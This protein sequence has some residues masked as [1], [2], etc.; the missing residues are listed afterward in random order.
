MHPAP[1]ACSAP[2]RSPATT[3]VLQDA[4]SHSPSSLLTARCKFFA[5]CPNAWKSGAPASAAVVEHCADSNEISTEP[6]S[7]RPVRAM[8]GRVPAAGR[9]RLSARKSAGKTRYPAAANIF[10]ALARLL[11][12][13]SGS[14]NNR[15]TTFRRAMAHDTQAAHGHM[16]DHEGHVE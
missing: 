7:P 11:K 15:K 6:R 2:T 9:A 12:S 14:W 1:A 10:G 8:K 13:Q 16:Q 4:S 3:P 5:T